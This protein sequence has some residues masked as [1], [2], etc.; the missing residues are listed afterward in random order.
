L[1]MVFR[2]TRDAQTARYPDPKSDLD[3]KSI[4]L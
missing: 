2:S 3:D 4:Q 1:Q